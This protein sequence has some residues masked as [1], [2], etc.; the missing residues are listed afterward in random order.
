SLVGPRRV[1]VHCH[2][3][4][5]GVLADIVVFAHTL[6]VIFNV[7]S[8]PVILVGGLSKKQFVLNSWFRNGH[9]LLILY[10]CLEEVIGMRC[11]LTTLE[12]YLRRL[13]G[14]ESYPGDFLGK[15]LGNLIYY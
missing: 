6:I 11:P 7:F 15:L 3:M 5:Y 14:E 1:V 10:V 4:I 9:I 2:S 8:V 12:G 13:A